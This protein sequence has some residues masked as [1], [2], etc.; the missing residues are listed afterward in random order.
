M[1]QFLIGRLATKPHTV[2][3]KKVSQFQFLI[4]RLATKDVVKEIAK[5]VKGFNSL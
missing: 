2:N 3:F 1:F 4:G 5:T